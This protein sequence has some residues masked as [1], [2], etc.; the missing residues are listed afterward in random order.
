[1][2]CGYVQYLKKHI[3]N[4][5]PVTNTLTILGILSKLTFIKLHMDHQPVVI[6]MTTNLYNL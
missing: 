4:I 3:V 6:K 1:M 2:L 5:L